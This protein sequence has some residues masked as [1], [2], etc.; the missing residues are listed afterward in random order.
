MGL[1]LHNRGSH[2]GQTAAARGLD[3]RHCWLVARHPAA[4]PILDTLPAA[5]LQRIRRALPAGLLGC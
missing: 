2:V 3:K 1:H 4:L 5:H